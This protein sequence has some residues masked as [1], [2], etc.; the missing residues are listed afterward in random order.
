MAE[1]LM[2]KRFSQQ[3]YVQSAGMESGDLDELMVAVMAEKSIDMRGHKARN[4]A[5]LDDRN[6]DLVIAFTPHAAEASKALFEGTDTQ[7]ELWPV[8]DPT[9]GSLDVR[10]MLNNYRSI[11]DFIDN[12]LQRRFGTNSA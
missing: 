3:L 6:Y 4:L 12:R 1:G 11:R 8:P 7:V 9:A 5:E 10:A 2:K